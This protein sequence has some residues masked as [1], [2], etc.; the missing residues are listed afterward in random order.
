MALLAA[1]AAVTSA[2]TAPAV[3]SSAVGVLTAVDP[4]NGTL[5]LKTDAGATVEVRFTPQSTLRRVAPG[6]R[7]LTNATPVT[8]TEFGVGDRVLARGAFAEDQ[9]SLAA[10]MV[11]LMTKSDLAQKAETE[12]ALWQ[13]RGVMGVVSAVNADAREVTINQR[14][15]EAATP[16]VIT[17]KPNA[18]IRRYAQDSVRFADAKPGTVADIKV[19]DQVRALGDRSEDG[20]KFTAE[21]I[22]SGT[23]RNVAGTVE[24]VDAAKGEL[25]LR[26]LQTKKVV[27]VAVN[28][29]ATLRRLPPMV[30][31]MMASGTRGAGPGMRG[32]GGPGMGGPPTGAPG[33]APA[34]TPGAPPQAGP[35][36]PRAGRPGAGG[37]GAP[38]GMAV[39]SGGPGG[40]GMGGPGGMRRGG[41]LSSMIERLPALT[42]AE[43][44]PGDAL[45]I[46]ST[47][48]ADAARMTAITMLAGVEPLLTG[49]S[50]TMQQVMGGSL[51][52]DLGSIPQ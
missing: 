18:G 23:F 49:P 52:M 30:A 26:D 32:P 15:V 3:A 5:T 50:Q 21:E 40:S 8:A 14:G 46:A 29:E 28:S 4:T 6:A 12:R 51:M 39:E 2:Q 24:S 43:L 44:K 16:L 34:G 7:D 25:R 36:G 1:M 10:R 27:S 37:P 13:R 38:G 41:D 9:K 19:G 33:E 17:L 20:A 35:G 48:S 47:A 22:V 11:V 42:L 31:Q 45:I